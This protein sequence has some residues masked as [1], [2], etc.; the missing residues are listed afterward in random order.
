MN[1]WDPLRNTCNV[2]EERWVSPAE[3]AAQAAAA[4]AQGGR[5]GGGSSILGGGGGRSGNKLSWRDML[6]GADGR[7]RSQ[8]AERGN[9]G[10]AAGAAGGGVGLA[11]VARNPRDQAY[12]K[13]VSMQASK[14]RPAAR[15]SSLPLARVCVCMYESASAPRPCPAC[16]IFLIGPNDLSDQTKPTPATTTTATAT[17]QGVFIRSQCY[18]P[19]A[20]SRLAAMVALPAQ[21][22]LEGARR[23]YGKAAQGAW[24][25]V[26]PSEAIADAVGSHER[27]ALERGIVLQVLSEAAEAQ[28][29]QQSQAAAAP[30]V[31]DGSG[32]GVKNKAPGPGLTREQLAA[33]VGRRRYGERA[34]E[35]VRM[36]MA[37]E[38]GRV[39]EALRLLV[40]DGL[41]WRVARDAPSAEA[42]GGIIKPPRKAFYYRL[43]PVPPAAGGS[44]P[45]GEAVEA[46]AAGAAVEEGGASGSSSSSSSSSSKENDASASASYLLTRP[47]KARKPWRSSAAAAASAVEALLALR[48]HGAEAEAGPEEEER[49][50][51]ADEGEEEGEQQAAAAAPAAEAEP[52]KP[53]PGPELAANEAAAANDAA[54]TLVGGGGARGQGG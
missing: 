15:P 43:A 10:A 7:L 31:G 8:F 17:A 28:R 20:A 42:T 1:V 13:E 50:L 53:A 2:P 45:G 25:A 40:G 38:K 24:A 29:V 19:P 33:V 5:A 35:S 54:A 23:V 4:A 21:G 32:Q 27:L 41:V 22:L 9:S 51:G 6:F 46:A 26:G 49:P 34:W 16:S 44:A 3:Q 37:E 18:K 30:G 48:R 14:Q 12:G 36:A 52:D 47:P 11:F 39:E